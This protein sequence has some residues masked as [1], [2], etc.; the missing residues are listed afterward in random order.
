[1]AENS[2]SNRTPGDFGLPG[3]FGLYVHWPF[4]RSKCPYCD[5]NS[6]VAGGAIDHVLWQRA[7][8][9]ELD[10]IGSQT[11]G[12]QLN[13]V[14]FGGGTPSLMAPA[15]VAAILDRAAHWW[16]LDAALEVTL[17]ANPT[18]TEAT[19]LRQ[20]RDAGINRVSLGVQALDDQA[21]HFL[22]REHTVRE[23]LVAVEIAS[24]TV[25]RWSLDLIYGRP[26]QAL[27]EW[28]RELA[29]AM[30]H[31]GG[32][33]SAYQLTIEPGTRFHALARSGALVMPD[34]DDLADFFDLTRRY[35]E[36]KG[37]TPYEISNFARPGEESR[38]NLVYWRY[39]DYAGIGPGAH[40]RLTLDVRRFAT[41]TIKAPAAWL[42][43]VARRGHAGLTP[44]ELGV[45][46]Q[47]AEMV[48][49]GLRLR[50][51]IDLDRLARLTGGDAASIL[52]TPSCRTLIED[53]WLEP[54]TGRL[55]ATEAGVG[56][57]NTLSSRLIDALADTQGAQWISSA[58]PHAA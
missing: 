17:E 45:E 21:L 30:A 37:L 5:F 7:L 19:R 41:R 3:G 27:A 1:M 22:G 43:A 48:L 33:L 23:A 10:H 2:L 12:R 26:G 15:T 35:L 18:S 47:L 49:M 34:D 58:P 38:H 36:G 29:V 24:N 4:C 56:R 11:Q 9:A 39:G 46:D 25:N 28:E 32:H 50:E 57:L 13:S 16:R 40:G 31:V 55:R 42:E 14:F 44:D 6:H 20:F 52:E 54:A 51:G 53:G 8:L